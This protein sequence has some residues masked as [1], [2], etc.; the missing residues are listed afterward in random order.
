[1]SKNILNREYVLGKKQ[2]GEDTIFPESFKGL[3]ILS[4]ILVNNIKCSDKF[5]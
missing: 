3:N 2:T 4:K 5:A 1:M